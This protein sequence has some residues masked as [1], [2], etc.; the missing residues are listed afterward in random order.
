MVW[1]KN[2]F[3]FI[4]QKLKKLN[5]ETKKKKKI[6]EEGRLEAVDQR[7]LHLPPW[8]EHGKPNQSNVSPTAD[9]HSSASVKYNLPGFF[10]SFTY[11]IFK[12]RGKFKVP[13]VFFFWCP[14]RHQNKKYIIL[15]AHS[16]WKKYVQ[17]WYL[18]V[19]F[20]KTKINI[21]NYVIFQ[22]YNS[23]KI[24]SKVLLRV[25]RNNYH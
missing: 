25:L 9:L 7:H 6:R 13:I 2:I 14:W 11:V 22:K 3:W 1:N 8:V 16:I 19:T 23:H 4:F 20:V 18:S 17:E 5:V 12:I 24:L 21:W 10:V 15:S